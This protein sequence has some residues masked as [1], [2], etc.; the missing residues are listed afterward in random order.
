MFMYIPQQMIVEAG[1]GDDSS[2]EVEGPSTSASVQS[3]STASSSTIKL[4]DTKELQALEKIFPGIISAVKFLKLGVRKITLLQDPWMNTYNGDILWKELG[5][6]IKDIERKKL[7]KNIREIRLLYNEL[8]KS[9]NGEILGRVL[10]T[11]SRNLYA[12]LLF[13]PCG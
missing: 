9:D 11:V 2:K 7:L 8:C 13:M 1:S 10:A 6:I 5:K 4:L 12:S 3:A